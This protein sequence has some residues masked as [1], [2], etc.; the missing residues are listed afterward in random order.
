MI[1]TFTNCATIII[2][3]F[4]GSRLKNGLPAKY[5]D[6]MMTGMGLAAS[7][8]GI[9]AVAG[10][11]P[12]S[13]F[14]VLF[15]ISLAIGGLIGQKLEIDDKF[16]S[17]A[18]KFGKD[19]LARGLSTAVL[20]FC[21]GTLSILGPIQSALYGD[22][23][24]LFTNATLDLV[25]SMVLA[26]NFGFGISLA[27]VVLF[28]WQGSIYLLAGLLTPFLTP[29]LMCEISIIGGILIF[30]SG[31]SILEIKKIPTINLLPAL[32]VPPVFFIIKNLIV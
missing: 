23:T 29:E 2:G 32:L 7:M 20:L 15:I 31:I 5:K 9:N 3:S 1:G 12:N 4:I 26:A 17:V 25:T 18:N 27:A 16:Q 13:T 22:H 21:I 30:S 10:N 11:M 8:L 6:I 28:F 24:Y 14:P 19:G